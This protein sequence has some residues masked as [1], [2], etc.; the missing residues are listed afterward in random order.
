MIERHDVGAEKWFGARQPDARWTPVAQA[1]IGTA[2]AVAVGAPLGL[3]PPRLWAG[4]RLGGVV[5]GG[6]AVA[7]AAATVVPKVRDALRRRELPA[8]EGRW[9][10]L[11]IPLGTVWAEETLFRG[12]LQTVGSEV[13]GPI[14][15]RL[16]QAVAFGLWHVPDARA[17]DQSVTGTV[18]AT[19]LAGWVFGWLAQRS[20]SL[21]APVLA[22]LAV[23][24]AGAVA[25][26]AVQRRG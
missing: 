13:F 7:V 21:L 18:L 2:L 17:A 19:G 22:H 20:G 14:G 6:I 24:E 5:A 11:E 9:L 8:D 15:G 16:L 3:R 1:A 26:V 25:A 4:L 10:A 12:A 23:N